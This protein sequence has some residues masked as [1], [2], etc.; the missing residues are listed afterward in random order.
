MPTTSNKFS[1]GKLNNAYVENIV[2]YIGLLFVAVLYKDIS[3]QTGYAKRRA[4]RKQG[5]TKEKALH[6]SYYKT[7]ILIIVGQRIYLIP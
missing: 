3:L 7:S 4:L 1:T 6:F 5:E 2:K